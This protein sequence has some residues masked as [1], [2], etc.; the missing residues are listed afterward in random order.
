MKAIVLAGGVILALSQ[1][2]LAS[3]DSSFAMGIKGGTTGFGVE[4]AFRLSD[5]WNLRAAASGLNY[6][7]DFTKENIDYKGDLRL[8]NASLMA[9]WH[10]F[11]GSF[12]VSAGAFANNNELK[13]KAQGNLEIGDATYDASLDAK[14]DWKSFAPYAGIGWGNSFKG[15]RL[16]LMTDVGVMFTGSPTVRLEG[17][18]QDPALLPFFEDDL[19]REEAKLRDELSDLKYYPVL[20]IGLSYR[21]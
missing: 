1:I 6:G 20:T 2:S 8:R 4:A 10:T 13:G 21:F 14:V 11:G 16:T 9:D 3:A 18:V 12:R 17:N 5:S 15:G 19:R 7:R